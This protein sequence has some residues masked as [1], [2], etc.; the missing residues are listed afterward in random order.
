VIHLAGS[1]DSG[2]SMRVPEKYFSNNTGNTLNLLQ[3]MLRHGI[4]KFIF[5]SSAA[6]YGAPERVP[7][8]EEEFTSPANAYG[9]SKL[10]VERM[11]AWFRRI[12]GLGYVSLRYFNAAGATATLGELHRPESHLIP[13]VLQAAIGRRQ[14]I[15]IFGADYPTKDG[16][17]VRDYIHV[18]DVAQAHLLALKALAPGEQRV[19]NLGNGNGHTVLEVVEA[20]RRVTGKAI[21]AT[22][23]PRRP[24]DPAML[25]ASSARIRAELGWKPAC[26]DLEDIIA[27]AWRWSLDQQ[28]RWVA[29]SPEL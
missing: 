13:L 27:S 1:I 12:H 9:E 8:T 26:G 22:I 19:Y 3:G 20:A 23:G 21:P 15:V 5:S 18:S 28:P 17:C 14:E 16:T 24:G 7:I 11:L 6:V 29:R 2:E 10:M 25:V 4:L